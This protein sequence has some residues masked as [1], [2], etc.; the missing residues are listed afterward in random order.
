[1]VAINKMLDEANDI[2]PNI[3]L[4]RQPGTSVSFLDIFIEN[5]NGILAA[6][7]Y[8]KEV[9]ES[10]IVPLKSDHPRHVFANIIDGALMRAI[11]YSST[12]SVFNEE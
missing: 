1:M 12:L 8:H 10:Y 7:V 6:S 3:E 4:V 5:R 9:A 11:H 2:H